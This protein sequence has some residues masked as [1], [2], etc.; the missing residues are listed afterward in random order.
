MLRPTVYVNYR[1]FVIF[2]YLLNIVLCTDIDYTVN[3][4][5]G[6]RRN[7]LVLCA[8]VLVRVAHKNGIAFLQQ[9]RLYGTDNLSKEFICYVR[10]NNTDALRF[11]GSEP[12]GIKI[13]LVAVLINNIHNFSFGL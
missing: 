5:G 12:F 10:N 11:I 9:R 6:K 8:A 1:Y 4:F 7:M 2:I 3:V 13:Y